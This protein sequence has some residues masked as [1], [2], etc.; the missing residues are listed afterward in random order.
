MTIFLSKKCNF[1][2]KNKARLNRNRNNSLKFG[3][4]NY[5]VYLTNHSDPDITKNMTFFLN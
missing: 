4:S 3:T 5:K 2:S 1:V